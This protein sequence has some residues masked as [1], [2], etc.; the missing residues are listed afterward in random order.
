MNPSFY[1]YFNKSLTFEN[2]LDN[3]Y[4]LY[5]H[6]KLTPKKI[7]KK[8]AVLFSAIALIF[9]FSATSVEAQNVPA[10]VKKEKVVSAKSQV[11]TKAAAKDADCADK[12]K[13]SEKAADC[14]DKA[15][16]SDC[17]TTCGE[18]KAKDC[19]TATKAS[20]AKPVPAPAKK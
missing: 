9:A 11:S 13:T 5:L 10:K 12:A 20:T 19:G 7:M 6:S 17:A 2:A 14:S 15:V 1:A 16:K 3:D 18:A 8:F 4:N